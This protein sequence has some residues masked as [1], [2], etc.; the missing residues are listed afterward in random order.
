PCR[1]LCLRIT[2]Q[3]MRRR[4]VPSRTPALVAPALHPRGG[5]EL[6]Q[7]LESLGRLLFSSLGSSMFADIR[8]TALQFQDS[9]AIWTGSPADSRPSQRLSSSGE[10]WTRRRSCV[11]G[12]PDFAQRCAT[13]M[14]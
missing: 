12:I 11:T 9:V 10:A 6:I 1:T 2:Q 7:A 14:G 13:E 5:V 8:E 3:G 4:R